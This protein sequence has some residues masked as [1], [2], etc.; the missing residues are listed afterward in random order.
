MLR[1]LI[2]RLLY[3]CAVLFGVLVLI[4]V[5][6]RL[7]PQDPVMDAL[8]RSRS[9]GNINPEEYEE[10]RQRMGLDRPIAVQFVDYVGDVLHGDFG[11]SYIQR[12]PVSEILAKG[13]PVSMKV[14]LVA[15]GIQIV[16]GGLIGVFAAAKQ[17]SLYDRTSMATA[18]WLGSIPQLVVGI[19][20]IVIFGVQLRWLPIRGWGTLEGWIL[21]LA[22]L[23]LYG[24]AQFARFD[25]AAILEQ[26]RQDFVRTARAKGLSERRVL[27]GH[28]LRNALIPIITFI[29]P[30]VA[31]LMV[32]NFVVETMFGI[33]GIAYYSI[34]ALTRGDYPVAQATVFL[35]AAFTILVNLAIDLAYG[36]IDPRVRIYR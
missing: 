22:T 36:V 3:S 25:R 9:Q 20:L 31:F 15:L 12:R 34:S 21:P 33:P 24:I 19:F 26:M 17:N 4:F 2:R 18:I 27:V 14:G 6:I 11:D 1:Y 13:I 5:T 32:G 28:V 7:S 23:S 10:M 8:R 16:L 29:G 35:F 30:S